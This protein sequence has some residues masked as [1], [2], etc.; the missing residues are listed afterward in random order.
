[1]TN[2]NNIFLIGYRGTG[3]TTVAQGLARRLGWDAVDI[4]DEIERRA[5]ITIASIFADD[6]EAAFRDL[7]SEILVDLC[8]RDRQMVSLGG[9]TVVRPENR[10]AI[11]QSGIVVWLTASVDTLAVRLDADPATADRRPNLTNLGGR[12]EI[13]A[14]LAERT[15]FYREC[16]NLAV[17][18]EGKEPAEVVQEIVAWL[19]SQ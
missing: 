13:E 3:K 17:D 7:E 15:P 12:S 9:G 11:R 14:M 16:A 8:Q 5:G 10:E 2:P 6:G 19:N 18:T 4:D 1:M